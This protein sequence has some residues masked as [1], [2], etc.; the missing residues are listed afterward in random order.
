M[1]NKPGIDLYQEVSNIKD[2]QH[3]LELVVATLTAKM[4]SNKAQLDDIKNSI[5]RLLWIFLGGFGS[6]VVAFVVRGGLTF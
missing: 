6:A 4:D 5:N 1:D 3:S 2:R